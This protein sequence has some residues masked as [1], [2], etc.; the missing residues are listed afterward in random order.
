MTRPDSRFGQRPVSDSA[1][2][3]TIKEE[4]QFGTVD[5]F[6]LEEARP[7]FASDEEPLSIGV[8]CDAVED[9]GRGGG[10]AQ[11]DHRG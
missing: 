8:P 5:K 11:A 10:R 1:G 3:E 9:L 4:P 7:P 6:D 2:L